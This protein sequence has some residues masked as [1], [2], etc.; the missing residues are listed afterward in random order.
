MHTRT[1]KWRSCACFYYCCKFINIIFNKPSI[2]HRFPI[3]NPYRLSAWATAI[4]LEA[5]KPS[6][7]SRICSDHFTDKDY[8]HR[9]GG[10]VPRL[11]VDAVPSVFIKHSE[12]LEEM[13]AS[14]NEIKRKTHMQ[15]NPQPEIL[16][17]TYYAVQNISNKS[18][19]C[20]S[21]SIVNLRRRVK[22]LQRQTQ[23]QRHTLKK[24]CQVIAEL[25]TKNTHDHD[26]GSL[27][28]VIQPSS[29]GSP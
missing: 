9:S 17:H 11:R 8:V 6:G 5:W 19:P 7:S 26:P 24:L 25:K 18:S 4:K 22:T 20:R 12:H 29:Y 21:L 13:I 1:I 28:L 15:P 10:T 2:F 14:E 27:N 23:R 3:N 16:D